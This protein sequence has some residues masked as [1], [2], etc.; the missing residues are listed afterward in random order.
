MAERTETHQKE[1]QAP[2]VEETRNTAAFKRFNHAT[3]TSDPKLVISSTIDAAVGP[4]VL[5]HSRSPAG[6]R[7]LSHSLPPPSPPRSARR[8]SSVSSA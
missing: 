3:D 2:V 4:D 6:G 5:T 1:G 8:R 7:R